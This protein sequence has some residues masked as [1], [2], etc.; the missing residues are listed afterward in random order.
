MKSLIMGTAGHVDHGKTAL[1]QAL[2]GFNCDTHP[3][4]RKRGITMN[5]GFSSLDID[6]NTK[7]GIVDVPGHRDFVHTMVGGAFG[8]DFVLLVVAADSGVMPQTKEHVR[9]MEILGVKKG[10]IVLNKID[11]VDEELLEMTKDEVQEFMQGTF[12]QDA[13]VK[14]ISAIT[15]EGIEELKDSIKELSL[16]IEEKRKGEIF[17]LYIDR[18]FSVSGFGTVVTGTSIGGSLSIDDKVYLL[19]ENKK[20]LRIRKMEQ[21]GNEVKE[22]KAGDRGSINLVGLERLDFERGMLISD[23]ILPPTE[24]IDVKL[25]TNLGKN[26]PCS[27]LQISVLTLISYRLLKISLYLK[28]II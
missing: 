27:T 13:P 16:T 25:S 6:S 14:E 8:I 17:R 11:L 2:T 5:L 22:I 10:I 7:L 28:T 23:R 4:E 20:K 18:I 19:P 21:Y 24:I 1:I 9:I 12:L 26:A 15:G 3:E